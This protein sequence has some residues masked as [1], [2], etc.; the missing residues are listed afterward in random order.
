MIKIRSSVFVLVLSAVLNSQ[1]RR[2]IF[3]NPGQPESPEVTLDLRIPPITMV[4][5]SLTKSSVFASLVDI[6]G[7]PS[8]L[9]PAISSFVISNFIRIR[10]SGV[11]VG[12]TSSVRSIF[13]DLTVA[14]P[15]ESLSRYGHT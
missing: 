9:I 14:S 2:G 10:S 4:S 3:F 13:L 8:A 11:T 12:V 15:D 7:V 6:A 5:P 1:P